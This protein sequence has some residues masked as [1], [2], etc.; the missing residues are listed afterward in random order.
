MWVKAET[1]IFFWIE[2]FLLIFNI[3]KTFTED[4]YSFFLGFPQKS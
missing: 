4:Y 1:E 3:Y 2:R